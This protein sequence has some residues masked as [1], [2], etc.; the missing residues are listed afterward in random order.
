MRIRKDGYYTNQHSCFLLQYHLVLVTKFRRPVLTGEL[1]QG[2]KAYLEAYFKKQGC[3]LQVMECMPD[4]VH[5]LFDAPPQINLANF[6]NALKSA[7]AR[8]MRTDYP[9]QVRKF[10]WREDHAYFWSL[11]YFIGTVSDKT[12]AAVKRYIQNQKTAHSPTSDSKNQA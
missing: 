9:D 10:Y 8:R 7:S 3:V 4:H 1:E 2:L 12:E 11:S 5:M 6:V